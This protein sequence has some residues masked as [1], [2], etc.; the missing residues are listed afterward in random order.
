MAEI[1]YKEVKLYT[2]KCSS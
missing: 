1:I 2:K